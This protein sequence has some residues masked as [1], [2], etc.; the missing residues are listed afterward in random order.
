MIE[1]WNAG[2]E[3]P[4]QPSDWEHARDSRVT[5]TKEAN[6]FT[7]V[8]GGERYIIHDWRPTRDWKATNKPKGGGSSWHH[9]IDHEEVIHLQLTSLRF[10]PGWNGGNTWAVPEIQTGFR[11]VD[12]SK[13]SMTVCEAVGMSED[14]RFVRI[15]V[16]Q[17]A[18]AMIKLT[19]VKFL[20]SAPTMGSQ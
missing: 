19:V 1:S 17:F 3:G 12:Q 16:N 8:R 7:P 14:T 18:H 5:P 20:E 9:P 11:R 2:S 15:R 10:N 4:S 6:R 13:D